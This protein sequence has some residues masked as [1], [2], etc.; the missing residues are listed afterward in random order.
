[1]N[2][3]GPIQSTSNRWGFPAYILLVVVALVVV[4]LVWFRTPEVQVPSSNDGEQ[5]VTLQCA[6]AGPSRW[7]APQVR[8]GQEISS[9]TK[10]VPFNLQVMKNDLESLRT[11][12]ACGQARDA[13]TNLLI[14]TT[15]AAGVAIL[16][17]HAALNRRRQHQL[18]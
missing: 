13:H 17:G 18:R 1:M 8:P 14:V 11:G 7:D 5:L 16:L 15:F 9:D 3:Q 10:M 12:L 4:M 2:S 6:N